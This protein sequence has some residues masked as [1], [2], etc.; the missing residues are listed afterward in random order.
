MTYNTLILNKVP[1]LSMLGRTRV[2]L[3]C[4]VSVCSGRL[5]TT[6]AIHAAVGLHSFHAVCSQC[7]QVGMQEWFQFHQ[8][9]G[10]LVQTD[11]IGCSSPRHKG[12][13]VLH[14]NRMPG[15]GRVP[16]GWH[17]LG[18]LSKTAGT[19]LLHWNSL[20]GL[21]LHHWKG[22]RLPDLQAPN[23]RVQKQPTYM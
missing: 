4:C 17:Q 3:T 1:C 18:P 6:A 12:H 11:C 20:T 19:S 7:P 9:N 15:G 16:R 22:C 13:V 8:E 5:I 21:W 2:V 10:E 14:C 23:G